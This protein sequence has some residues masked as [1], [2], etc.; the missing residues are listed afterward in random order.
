MKNNS[1]LRC[2]NAPSFSKYDTFTKLTPL[3]PNLDLQIGIP[4]N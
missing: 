1:S 2:L 3:P 4:Y